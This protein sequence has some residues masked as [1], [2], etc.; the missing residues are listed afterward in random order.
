MGRFL[1]IVIVLVAVALLINKALKKPD[2][3][4]AEQAE[5][6]N[7]PA[8]AKLDAPP[9]VSTPSE[10]ASAAEEAPD[11]IFAPNGPVP[12]PLAAASLRNSRRFIVA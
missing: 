2:V 6:T 1:A 3:E 5:A 11:A 10:P 12:K 8:S 4:P 9:Q 7:P